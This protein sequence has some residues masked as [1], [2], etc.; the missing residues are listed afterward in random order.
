MKC[1][2]RTWDAVVRKWRR[3]LHAFDDAPTQPLFS[4][5]SQLDCC[6]DDDDDGM[7]NAA[8]ALTAEDL[9][10]DF[11]EAGDGAVDRL[12][13]ASSGPTGAGHVMPP[14]D[15]AHP[16]L[17]KTIDDMIFDVAHEIDQF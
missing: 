1:S 5:S 13:S 12:G 9:C 16:P 11:A 3:D 14:T 2:K 10:F 15:T 17:A 7:R 4:G 8:V 6:A